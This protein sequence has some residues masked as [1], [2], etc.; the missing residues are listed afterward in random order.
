MDIE[1]NVGMYAS[2]TPQ[3]AVWNRLTRLCLST[4][5]WSMLIGRPPIGPTPCH[6][7][8]VDL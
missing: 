2:V 4:S 7:L 1:V 8:Y 3:P 6:L 5:Y